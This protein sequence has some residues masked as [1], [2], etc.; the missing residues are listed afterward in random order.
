[1]TMW[2]DL[3]NCICQTGPQRPGLQEM[4][5]SL[6]RHTVCTGTQCFEGEAD[7]FGIT[8]APGTITTTG[9]NNAMFFAMM[10]MMMM[11]AL[12][13]KMMKPPSSSESSK[14]GSSASHSNEPPPPPPTAS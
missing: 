13:L 14:P 11:V 10:T 2:E 4:L 6:Q 3:M 8:A 1:M 9:N 12:F 5:D 7:A